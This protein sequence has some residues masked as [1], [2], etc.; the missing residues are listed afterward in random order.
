MVRRD[1]LRVDGD[2]YH[3]GRNDWRDGPPLAVVTRVRITDL[4][5]WK[6][7]VPP[8]YMPDIAPYEPAPGG[9]GNRGFVLGVEVE[10]D[11][12]L[13]RQL[14]WQIIHLRGPWTECCELVAENVRRREESEQERREADEAKLAAAGEVIAALADLG[15]TAHLDYQ[16]LDYIKVR[17]E[18]VKWLLLNYNSGS[19]FLTFRGET[20]ESSGR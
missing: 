3:C 13:G 2:Y 1:E 12:T 5:A 6:P 18:D 15:K 9:T 7:R 4:R 20:A 10:E 17:T 16:M 14:A 11:G 8:K 19:L